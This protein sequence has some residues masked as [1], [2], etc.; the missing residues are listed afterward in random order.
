MFVISLTYVCELS[1]VERHIDAHMEYLEQHYKSGVFL[2]SG[3]KVP[4]TGGVILA[5]SESLAALNK[6]L[7]ADPFK[8]HQL[9]KYEVTEFIP[10]MTSKELEFLQNQ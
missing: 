7:S 2:A 9:A 1:E 4:R 6:I 3:R 10:A 8:V 5:R